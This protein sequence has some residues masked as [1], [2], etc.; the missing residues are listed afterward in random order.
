MY[1]AIMIPGQLPMPAEITAASDG[2]VTPP[3]GIAGKFNLVDAYDAW[4][5][6]R[7]VGRQTCPAWRKPGRRDRPAALPTDVE[8]GARL[9]TDAPQRHRG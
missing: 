2:E 7:G 1:R 9:P 6:E 5:L 4:D 8:R 3:D